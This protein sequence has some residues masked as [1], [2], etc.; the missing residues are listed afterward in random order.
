[1]NRVIFAAIFFVFSIFS[2]NASEYLFSSESVTEGHP[3]KICDQISDA[4]LDEILSHDKNGRVACE[5]FATKGT[6]IVAGEITTSHHFDVSDIVRGVLKD[7]GYDKQGLGI[8]DQECS[9]I[10]LINKQSP[11]ISQGVDSF[12]GHEQ[13]AGDQGLMFG[14]AC[15]ETKELMPL[16]I[17]LSHKLTKR[18]ADV[19]KDNIL[20]WVRP[21]GKA[22]VTVKYVDNVPVEITSVVIAIQHN[23]DVSLDRLR[24]EI[25]EY[26]IKPVCC[27]Y[28]TDETKYFINETGLFVIGGPDGDTGLTGR[29]IIIDT[30]GGMGRH[31]GGCFS[32]KDP[33]KV[34]RSASY[35]ARHIAKNI[36][37]AKLA[38]RCEVQLAYCIGVAEPLSIY[39]NTFNT[40]VID[41]DIL[42]NIIRDVFCL[43]PQ[44]IIEYLDLKRPIYKKTAAY[45]H[46]GREEEGFSWEKIDKVQEL[47]EAVLKY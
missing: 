41:E 13:G 18:L 10:Q 8:C 29:K 45:G 37:A 25:T 4:I 20:P 34:D 35:M 7:I 15:D 39:V 40:S 14:Y 33:S 32:G 27:E 36:V 28:I 31:G 42:E 16:P 2:L 22:Q 24:K 23:P 21:D 26:V 12:E 6:I 43:K 44:E 46:F 19:R 1:M 11:D 3:D 17:S 38:T 30:Y 47:Q 9:V 5:T